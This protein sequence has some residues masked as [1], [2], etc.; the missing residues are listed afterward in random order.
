MRE[1]AR[2]ELTSSQ[3]LA[4]LVVR[5]EAADTCARL[6]VAAQPA[7]HAW[8]TDARGDVLADVPKM[9]DGSLAPQGPVCVRK[10]DAIT[11]HVEGTGTWT[12]RYVA[13]A[14]P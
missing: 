2:G 1:T 9:S 7:V 13:W 4:P 3:C 10:G 14:T 12:A 11:L 6:A 8:L 5:A